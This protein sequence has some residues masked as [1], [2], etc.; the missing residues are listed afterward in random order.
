MI[1]S[2][3]I[4][5]SDRPSVVYN[6]LSLPELAQFLDLIAVPHEWVSETM[7]KVHATAGPV[8]W[9]WTPAIQQFCVDQT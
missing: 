2:P 6:C 7:I 9:E 8:L 1:I 3:N 5:D 4:D